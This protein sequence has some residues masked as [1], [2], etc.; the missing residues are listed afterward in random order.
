MKTTASLFAPIVLGITSA[1][2]MMLAKTFGGIAPLPISSQSFLAALGLYLVV[3]VPIIAYFSV[4]LATGGDKAEFA[5]TL[6]RAWP[7]SLALFTLATGVA[8][9][10]LGI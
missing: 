1:L 10:G 2:Y 7:T 6:G 5:G 9:A 4:C 3:M 8:A